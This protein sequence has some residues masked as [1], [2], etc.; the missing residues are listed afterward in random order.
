MNIYLDL[1]KSEVEEEFL[2]KG[3]ITIAPTSRIP[4]RIIFTAHIYH[5]GA[6]PDN[7]FAFNA[8]VLLVPISSNMPTC[9]DDLYLPEPPDLSMGI[10]AVRDNIILLRRISM[11]GAGYGVSAEQWDVPED[12]RNRKAYHLVVACPAFFWAG[13]DDTISQCAMHMLLE[14][15][16]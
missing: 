7:Q 16:F 11:N 10:G 8:D 15:E 9:D 5:G 14:M 6:P 1:A 2:E 4:K 12:V 3:L 13:D